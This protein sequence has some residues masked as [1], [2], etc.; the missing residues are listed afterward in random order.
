MSLLSLVYFWAT[1]AERVLTLAESAAFYLTV[2]SLFSLRAFAFS[3]FWLMVCLSYSVRPL[4]FSSYLFW[5]EETKSLC[6]KALICF[7]L[8]TSE[9]FWAAAP[10]LSKSLALSRLVSYLSVS[11]LGLGTFAMVYA[12]SDRM[13]RS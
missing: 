12:F 11:Y 7:C 1:E 6:L 9:W 2:R 5:Q 10:S 4:T 8:M 13:T 3:S